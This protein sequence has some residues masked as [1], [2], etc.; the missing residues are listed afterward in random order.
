M[1]VQLQAGST[2][3]TDANGFA[4]LETG[5]STMLVARQGDDVAFL[6]RWGYDGEQ[7]A[8]IAEAVLAVAED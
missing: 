5:S 3:T 8:S 1:G 4:T 7:K 2:G 6:E